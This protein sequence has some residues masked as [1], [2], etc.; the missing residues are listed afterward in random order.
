MKIVY[1]SKGVRG[2]VCLA[3][4]LRAGHRIAAVVAGGPEQDLESL[5]RD[6]HLSLHAP[7]N[8]NTLEFAELLGTL[9]AEIFVCSGYNRILKPMIFNIPHRGTINLHGGRLPFYRGAAPINWQII[10]GETVGGCCV[11]F[12]DEGID[13]GPIIRQELY[14]ITE[15]D[16]HASVLDKTL[17]IFPELLTEVLQGI[18][19]DNIRPLKQNLEEGC[20]YTRRYPDDSRINWRDMSD[21]QIHNL[22]RGMQGPFPHA[23]TFRE[24]E[25]IEI[26]HT[27][28]LKEDI[29]GVSGRVSLKRDDG[30]IVL[31]RNRGLLVN[32]IRIRG[33]TLNPAYI[34]KMG[35]MLS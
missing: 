33:E 21:V 1:F 24:N 22:V 34:F 15:D 16:T 4:A 5:C 18:E 14:P 31:C 20:Y 32:E 13:T 30:V 23:F 29:K 2:T 8:P 12:M 10:N 19:N 3:A 17:I 27:V 26:E 7:A 6:N 25:K 28:L 9:D 11:L 35:E